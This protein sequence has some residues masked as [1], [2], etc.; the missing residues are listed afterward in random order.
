MS[1][2]ESQQIHFPAEGEVT[3]VV[4]PLLSSKR[5]PHLKTRK[6]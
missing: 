2:G 3:V 1:E 4:R 6:V 5:R